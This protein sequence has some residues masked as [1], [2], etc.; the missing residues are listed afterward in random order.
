MVCGADTGRKEAND[1][2]EDCEGSGYGRG[3][4]LDGCQA[5]MFDNGRGEAAWGCQAHKAAGKLRENRDGERRDRG[6]DGVGVGDNVNPAETAVGFGWILERLQVVGHRDHRKEDQDEHGEGDEL[7][8]PVLLL[9]FRASARGKSRPHA[10][11][12]RGQQNPSE[13]EDEFHSQTRFYI[14]G[15]CNRKEHD[16]LY[17]GRESMS[18]GKEFLKS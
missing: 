9:P 14:R 8:A 7:H 3:A 1:V 11:H 5:G 2:M 13:I 18:A 10:K 17:V 4:V 6:E 15:I 12:Q 16:V